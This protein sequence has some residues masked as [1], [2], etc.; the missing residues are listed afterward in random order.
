MGRAENHWNYIIPEFTNFGN[1][2]CTVVIVLGGGGGGGYGLISHIK[3]L[4]F[5]IL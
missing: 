2:S 4:F 5:V 1:D 3:V